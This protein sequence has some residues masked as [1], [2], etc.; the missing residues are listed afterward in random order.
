MGKGRASGG[1][2]LPPPPTWDCRRKALPSSALQTLPVLGAHLGLLHEGLLASAQLP[3]Q[4]L[5]RCPVLQGPGTSLLRRLQKSPW[6]SFKVMDKVCGHGLL[7]SR[8]GGCGAWLRGSVLTAAQVLLGP[9]AA[10]C[11]PRPGLFCLSVPG[12]GAG[13]AALV[14]EGPPAAPAGLRSAFSGGG[15]QRD[16]MPVTAAPWAGA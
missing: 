9:A 6:V 2:F 15:R 4:Q 13:T 5:Q 10:L 12:T 1:Q 3:P 11:L 16:G 8:S 14:P 7:R